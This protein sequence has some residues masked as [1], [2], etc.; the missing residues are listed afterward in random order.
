VLLVEDDPGDVLMTGSVQGA[1]VGNRLT[2]YPTASRRWPTCVARVSTRTR[3]DLVLL[4]FNLP[5]D[6]REVLA[7]IER[8]ELRHPVVVLTTRRPRRTCGA[9][10]LHAN[11]HVTA[12]RPRPVHRGGPQDD[13]F[14]VSELRLPPP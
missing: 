3:P 1:K 2:W 13:E 11:A 9:A 4:D 10:K 12:G 5:C 14:F 8:P 6:G 7:E